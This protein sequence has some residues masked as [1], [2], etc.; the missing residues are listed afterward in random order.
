MFRGIALAFLVFPVAP[1]GMVAVPE[2]MS[3]SP[4][5]RAFDLVAVLFLQARECAC[6]LVRK[7]IGDGNE[8]GIALGLHDLISSAGATATAADQCDPNFVAAGKPHGIQRGTEQGE[9]ARVAVS[10]DS[11]DRDG[12][13]I[14]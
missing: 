10:G 1:F 2:A 12:L 13:A 5:V 11:K 3:K 4:K 7:G 6:G 9:G 14:C 8:L